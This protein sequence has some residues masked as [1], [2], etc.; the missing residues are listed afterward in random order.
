MPGQA[1]RAIEAGGSYCST[2]LTDRVEQEQRRRGWPDIGCCVHEL[3]GLLKRRHEHLRTLALDARRGPCS[4]H[5]D[6]LPCQ[7]RRRRYGG[8]RVSRLSVF[9]S[10]PTASVR[11]I[12]RR[13]LDPQLDEL[14]AAPPWWLSRIGV[15]WWASLFELVAEWGRDDGIGSAAHPTAAGPEHGTGIELLVMG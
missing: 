7:H 6:S 12:R 9:T 3:L 13:L 4:Q 8:G 1:P 15:N 11:R 10:S 5:A 2:G 14:S